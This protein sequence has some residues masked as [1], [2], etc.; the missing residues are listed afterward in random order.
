MRRLYDIRFVLFS[1]PIRSKSPK[2]HGIE[3]ERAIGS[4][5]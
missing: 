5:P 2:G 4:N 1:L 3:A